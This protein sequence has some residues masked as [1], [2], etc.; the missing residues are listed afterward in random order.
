MEMNFF[1]P[2]ADGFPPPG[3]AEGGGAAG[4]GEAGRHPRGGMMFTFHLQ[5]DQ[6]HPI[7]VNGTEGRPATRSRIRTPQASTPSSAGPTEGQAGQAFGSG[8]VPQRRPGGLPFSGPLDLPIPPADAAA[9]MGIPLAALFPGIPI[10][11]LPA[12]AAANGE[13]PQPHQMV[14]VMGPNGSIGIPQGAPGLPANGANPQPIPAGANAAAVAAMDQPFFLQAPPGFLLPLFGRF[15]SGEPAPDPEKA[16]EL[17]KSLPT[18]EKGLM[19]RIDRIYAAENVE[20]GGWKCGV[21]LE[22]WE[23]EE[24]GEGMQVERDGEA[25]EAGMEVKRLPCNHLF[26]AECLEP[27]F[28]TKHTW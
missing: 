25:G 9:P 3:A 23:T 28:G 21:C 8:S 6:A 10:P 26:H 27:W 4:A 17:L 2:L 19:K 20:E 13:Q 11:D 5:S 18:V 12:P 1:I 7:A 24:N 22:G 14:F 16:K 15:G